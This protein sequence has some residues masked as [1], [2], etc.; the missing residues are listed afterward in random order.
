MLVLALTDALGHLVEVI[1][2]WL[3]GIPP[4][5]PESLAARAGEVSDALAKAR[6]LMEEMQAEVQARMDLIDSLAA[7]TQEA[8]R[9]SAEATL[10]AGLNEE[11]AKAVDFQLDRALQ[12]RLGTLERKAQRREWGLATAGGLIVGLVVGV[13]SILLVHYLF[14]FDRHSTRPISS[15][16]RLTTMPSMD[17]A[18]L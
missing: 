18:G 12:A 11:Q 10:R 13:G 4:E 8:E 7:E 16:M 14:G 6:A 9:R 5:Q 1:F 3:L 17:A 15:T 2:R